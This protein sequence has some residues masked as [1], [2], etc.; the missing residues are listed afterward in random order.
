MRALTV[1]AGIITAALIV[2]SAQATMLIKDDLGGLMTQYASRFASVRDS[3]EKVVID[4]PCYSACTMLLGMVPREQV[5]VTPNAV[6]GFHAAWN[7]DETGRRVTSASATQALID[8]YPPHIRSWLARRGGL[9]PQMKFLRGHELASMYPLC[10]EGSP[11]ERIRSTEMTS[12]ARR[13]P[14]PP[15]RAFANRAPAWR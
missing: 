3:G 5:C 14:T 9:S 1:L 10:R 13:M 15:A 8:I 7:Y 2:T 6:L 4:G 11:R 12:S